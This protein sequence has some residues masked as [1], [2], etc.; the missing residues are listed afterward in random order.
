MAAVT[1]KN[2]WKYYG[3]TVAVSDLSLDCSDNSFL[4]ILGPSGCGKSSTLRMLAGLE[5]ITAGD[6]F[7]DDRRGNDPPPQARGNPLVFE[8]YAPYPPKTGYHNM[9]NPLRLR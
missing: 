1:L 9:I 3:K 5:H 2:V 8:E 7:F 4:C 6:V